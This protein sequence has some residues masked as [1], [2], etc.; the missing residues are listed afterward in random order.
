[1][2]S[3]LTFNVF[4][5]SPLPYIFNGTKSLYKYRLQ[6]QLE[7][8]AKINPDI[9]CLQE[10]YCRNSKN[11]YKSLENYNSFSGD[12]TS[13]TGVLIANIIYCIVA[14]IFYYIFFQPQPLL[15]IYFYKCSKILLQSS[16]LIEWLEGDET[17]LMILWKKDIFKLC[18][19][20]HLKFSNQEGDIMNYISPRGCITLILSFNNRDICIKNI[21][22]N[23]LG[24]NTARCKQV[25]EVLENINIP[26]II[27]GDLNVHENSIEVEKILSHN[28][29]DTFRE[30]NLK[31]NGYTW[32]SVNPLT[33]GWM[34]TENL[35]VDYIFSRGIDILSSKI[36][37][38]KPP[39]LSD[40]FGIL[41]KFKI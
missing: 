2:L 8:I 13:F 39:F 36:V 14:A 25:E 41:S 19:V 30:T 15:Y 20:N 12:K 38:D 40:H 32:N 22:L 23:A 6:L 31:D 11:M 4:P 3:V 17:G 10:L 5:G 37:F 27:A 24:E 16:A 34:R 29:K 35:R 9:I 18:S 26:T 1:M 28:F 7:E 33:K 21:H